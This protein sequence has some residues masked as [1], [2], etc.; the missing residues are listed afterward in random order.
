M[1]IAPP[2]SDSSAI[3]WKIASYKKD[4]NVKS[5]ASKI[6]L[7]L[8]NFPEFLRFTINRFM[9]A[10]KTRNCFRSLRYKTK[11]IELNVF[12]S[13]YPVLLT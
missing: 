6:L 10:M 4:K 3:D 7:H 1:F 11:F 9:H 2:V 13:N 5:V 12:K 8:A